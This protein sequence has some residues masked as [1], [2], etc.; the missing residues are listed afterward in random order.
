MADIRRWLAGHSYREIDG[1][2][3]MPMPCTARAIAATADRFRASV[4]ANRFVELL[5][6]PPL[7]AVIF[8]P[9]FSRSTSGPCWNSWKN[10]HDSLP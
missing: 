5:T 1:M 2:T 7:G 10:F 9:P 6:N 4:V 3:M 8:Q